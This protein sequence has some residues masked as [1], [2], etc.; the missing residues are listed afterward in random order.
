MERMQKTHSYL[1]ATKTGKEQETRGTKDQ[2]F[3][4]RLNGLQ[5]KKK[6]ETNFYLGG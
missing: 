6:K 1:E 4:D 3:E 5:K 2:K